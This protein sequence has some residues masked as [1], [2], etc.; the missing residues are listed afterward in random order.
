MSNNYDSS[1][2]IR[3]L[4]TFLSI[5]IGCSSET[6]QNKQN[7]IQSVDST[8]ITNRTPYDTSQTNQSENVKNKIIG[9]WKG[10]DNT[11]ATASFIFD[12]TNHATV[13]KNNEVFGGE[14]ERKGILIECTYEINYTKNPIWL[15]I[16]LR[17]KGER[18]KIVFM[19]GIVRFITDTKI[20][21]RVN[22]HDGRFKN[23]DYD[24]KVNT[25]VLDKVVN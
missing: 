23:F 12:N 22:F 24:D 25:I 15:D 1:I 18:T 3:S 5:C 6:T 2:I 13:V 9:E 19:S 8:A 11:G 20:E 7:K 4:F 17:K 14:M 21:Y 10:T 16:A